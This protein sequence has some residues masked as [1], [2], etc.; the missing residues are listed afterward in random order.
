MS[1][2]TLLTIVSLITILCRCGDL[3][4]AQEPIDYF[5]P[6][7]QATARAIKVVEEH[8]ITTASSLRKSIYELI[9]EGHY[10]QALNEVNFVLK[11]VPNHPVALQIAGSI[12]RLTKKFSIAVS[13]YEKALRLYPQHA[14]THAQYGQFLLQIDQLDN[15]IERLK[16]AVEIDPNLAA[17]YA[18][19]ANA[20]GKKGNTDLAREAA[21]KAR[22]L[23]FKEQLPAGQ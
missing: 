16:R 15:A 21:E 7:D 5:A 19:L 11:Y 13:Y 23:G 12:S 6:R 3:A 4:L 2:N 10:N 14:K 8:H 22:E 18:L 20:Y 9:G 17:G 1:R